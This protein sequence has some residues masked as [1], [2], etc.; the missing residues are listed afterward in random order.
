MGR[1]ISGES[2]V[3]LRNRLSKAIILAIREL[4]QQTQPDELSK[5]LAAFI[6]LSL[7]TISDSINK[8]VIAWEKRDY[9]LKAD[10]FRMDWAWTESLEIAMKKALFEE[11]WEEIGKI[12]IKIA[13]KFQGIKVSNNHRMGTP[14]VGAY[15]AMC[16]TRN[17][18][19]I[20]V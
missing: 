20:R 6:V 17:G 8:T 9:W 7:E 13:E 1:I 2:P 15:K 16:A 11:S 12:S 19:Q 5:D 4:M 3:T 10:K 18:Q 14:W